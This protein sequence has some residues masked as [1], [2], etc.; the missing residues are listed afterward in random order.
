[1]VVGDLAGGAVVDPADVFTL[2]LVPAIP[3]AETLVFDLVCTDGVSTWAQPLEVRVQAPDLEV[4]RV[5]VDDSASGNGDGVVQA[6]EV[7]DLAVEVKNHGSGK[8]MGLSG[9][10]SSTSPNVQLQV[11]SAGWPDLALREAAYA[12]TPFRLLETDTA[13][14]NW[15]LLTLSDNHGHSWLHWMELRTPT[16]PAI[17][18][19]DNSLGP[20]T[21]ALAWERPTQSH[22]KG[23][24]VYRANEETGPYE[25]ITEDI[26]LDSGFFRDD[27]LETLT[28]YYYHVTTVDS[29]GLESEPSPT[30][31]ASTAPPEVSNAFPLTT[32]GLARGPMTVG[33]LKGTGELYAVVAS[34][35]VMAVNASGNELLDGDLDSQTLGPISDQGRNYT[36]GGATLANLDGDPEPEILANSWDTRQTY[37]FDNDGSVL[38]GWPRSTRAQCWSM[39]S[40]GDLDGDGDLEVVTIDV[41]GRTYA[42]HH[43][44]TEV[45]DGD[46]DPAT[47]GVFQIRTGEIYNRSTISLFD[48]DGDGDEEML[49]GSNL[50]DGSTHN[51]V[52][53]LNEDGTQPPGWPKDMGTS[54]FTTSTVTVA[55]LDM[56]GTM[57]IILPMENDSLQVWTPDGQPKAGFPRYFKFN[58]GEL[59][60]RSSSVAVGN[61]D[62][63]PQLEM[64]FIVTHTITYSEV[65]VLEHD[66]TV[67]SGWPIVIRNASES[68]PVLADLDGDRRVDIALGTGG[69]SEIEP[70]RLHAWAADGSA[71][72][73][74]PLSLQGDPKGTPVVCD[75]DGD[76]DADLLIAGFDNLL[77]AYD[78][79]APW[80]PAL[81]PWAMFSGD[82]RR[83]GVYRPLTP[84]AVDPGD[85]GPVARSVVLHQ[86]VP[87]PFNPVTTIAFEV[88]G[89]E[90]A[91]VRLDVYD[92]AGRR[93]RTLVA[94]TMGPGTHEVRW[95]GVDA[96]GRRVASG[97][98]FARLQVAEQVRSLKM[99]LAK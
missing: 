19:A 43:D 48:V 12:V 41:L 5:V 87:N 29:T 21:N 63:D 15:V 52:H 69:G 60:G 58:A 3:D 40:A 53:C 32:N 75:F 33:D 22:L 17:L 77:H 47:Q 9:V 20:T 96:T 50:R 23:Y 39:C 46:N 71:I 83:S 66:G 56:D 98:Y 7:F 6:G 86:N 51:F 95:D 62:D 11:D 73:G 30:V 55:D 34:Q 68:S 92:I 59:D 65:M 81:A 44:G 57:E 28:R 70:D 91:R 35:L 42:W 25:E 49:Y 82:A 80:V 85:G 10:L 13:G 27:G 45:R 24:R 90:E 97:V 64:A 72:A 99:T 37:A 2:D 18:S 94:E 84:T 89:R 38:P 76:G 78:V 67:K 8:L 16:A 74:F 36:Y 31:T 1:V 26:L 54:G 14:E 88:P 4:T 79:P 93:V 61:L